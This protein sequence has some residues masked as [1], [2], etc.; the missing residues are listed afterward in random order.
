MKIQ[1][2]LK[3]NEVYSFV[4]YTRRS[5]GLWNS[6]RFIIETLNKIPGIKAEIVE[7]TDNND[8][9]REISRFKPDV[10]VIEAL[11]VVPSKFPILAR[12]HPKV[13]WYVHLH[14]HMPFLAL[15]GIAME[16]IVAYAKQGIGLIANSKESYEALS[17]I[18]S[19]REL[20]YLPNVYLGEMRRVVNRSEKEKVIDI[21]CFGAMRPLKNHLLQALAAIEFAR[22]KGK[23]LQ[24]H[25]NGSRTETGGEPVLKNL[26]SL[27][28]DG[29]MGRLIEHPWMEPEEF[30]DLLHNS[31]DIGMQV[32]L[33]ETFNV[34]SADYVTAGVPVVASK[35]VSWI[36]RCSQAPDN[37]VP[38]IL[39]AMDRAYRSRILPAWNQILL[40]RYSARAQQ[41]WINFCYDNERL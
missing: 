11:W 14:S 38:S 8:I 28:A 33:T 32:S 16:W 5:S 3:R 12:L 37:S 17:T 2:I 31:I 34:V 35:E 29:R 36:S 39:R 40:E 18:L 7:V 41:M 4:S 10:V 1:F 13:K 24:F 6:T 20:L 27:F 23:Y 15:E 25:I 30:L 21:G 26:R 22:K 19:R 9:D